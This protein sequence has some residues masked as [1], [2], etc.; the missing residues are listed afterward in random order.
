[1]DRTVDLTTF[2]LLWIIIDFV[3]NKLWSSLWLYCMLLRRLFMLRWEVAKSVGHK[4][5]NTVPAFVAHC[6]TWIFCN[7]HVLHVNIAMMR[8]IQYGVQP[9]WVYISASGKWE[10]KDTAGFKGASVVL[11][12]KKN[13]CLRVIFPWRFLIIFLYLLFH[14]AH[15]IHRVSEK[16]L[17]YFETKT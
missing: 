12:M 13:S 14:G 7:M 15:P 2:C 17:R 16:Y 11:Q 1:M 4:L 10:K 5:H 3:F 9:W 8:N 6:L